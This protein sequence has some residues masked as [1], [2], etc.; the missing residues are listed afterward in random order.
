M[1][2]TPE[3]IAAILTGGKSLRMG[4]DKS[5]LQID[6]QTL[7]QRTVGTIKACSIVHIGVS[8]NSSL[9]ARDS[10]SG[11]EY[12]KDIYPNKGP[13]SGIHSVISH[14]PS[15]DILV[16]PVD[17][18]LLTANTLK[19]LIRHGSRQNYMLNYEQSIMPLYIPAS[20]N[21]LGYLEKQLKH[22]DL[23]ESEQPQ[24]EKQKHLS[25]RGFVAAFANKQ[26]EVEDKSALFN[27]NT[28]KEWQKAVLM[29]KKLK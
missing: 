9:T 4:T 22:C 6:D 28:P 16:V 5:A 17:L 11:V 25:I 12:I 20:L 27:V 26:I 2:E 7:L 15:S 29:D 24:S 21:V 13:L 8:T 14:Y 19:T 1:N 10:L 3:I 18:P 23:N